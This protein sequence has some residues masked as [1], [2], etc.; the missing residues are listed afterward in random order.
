MI[1]KLTGH[2]SSAVLSVYDHVVASDI[3]DKAL[4]VLRD[5]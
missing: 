1:Q 5:I 2:K 3:K 4:D